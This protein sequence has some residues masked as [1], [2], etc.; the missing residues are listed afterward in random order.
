MP[1]RASAISSVSSGSSSSAAVV[2]ENTCVTHG[3]DASSKRNTASARSEIALER[4]LDAQLLEAFADDAVDEVLA[5][6][7]APAR[8]APDAR[9]EMGLADQSQPVAVEDEERHVMAAR[10]A[11]R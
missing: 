6:V 9:L 10:R 11:C 4:D 8:R 2:A 3:T 5:D 7:D 1:H